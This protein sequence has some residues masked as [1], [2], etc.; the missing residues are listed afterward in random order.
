MLLF[1]A[2][3]PFRQQF[4]QFRRR[5]LQVLGRLFALLREG[6]FSILQGLCGSCARFGNGGSAALIALFPGP[7][8][9]VFCLFTALGLFSLKPLG[10]LGKLCFRIA[11]FFDLG[12]NAGFPGLHKA[13]DRSKEKTL[14]Q[15][16]QQKEVDDGPYEFRDKNL[17]ISD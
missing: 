13:E 9:D 4:R 10:V 3:Q 17:G 8:Q 11:F 5:R 15:K 6:V 7:G 1:L 12:V 14:Q 2:E 16:Q